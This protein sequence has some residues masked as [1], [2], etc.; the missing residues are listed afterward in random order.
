KGTEVLLTFLDGDPDRPVIQ[1][2]VP[3]SETPSV[4]T[5]AGQTSSRIESG[6]GHKVVLED[7]EGKEGVGLFASDGAGDGSWIWMGKQSPDSFE[8]KSKGN[9]HELVIGQEDSFVLGSESYYTLGS[10]LDFMVGMATE[11][12]FAEKFAFE[13][14][15]SL[16]FKYGTH[17]EFGKSSETIK[18]SSDLL[19]V[20][21]V[22][23]RAGLDPAKKL[24]LTKVRKGMMGA[25]AGVGA[26]S[27]I[28]GGDMATLIFP[29]EKEGKE[30]FNTVGWTSLGFI[31]VGIIA[32]VIAMRSILKKLNTALEHAYS[33]INLDNSGI[34]IHTTVEANQGIHLGAGGGI[35][36]ES[37][38]KINPASNDSIV[39]QRPETTQG[40][41]GGKIIVE[42]VGVS[43]E[44]QGGGSINV[45]EDNVKLAKGT[46]DIIVSD[47]FVM[48]EAG[49]GTEG[50]ITLARTLAEMEQGGKKVS[51]DNGS[52]KMKFGAQTFTLSS[53]SIGVQ[54]SFIKLG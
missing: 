52:I 18:D 36:P 4:I 34:K 13:L 1:S 51:I 2:A 8:V 24:L 7:Q 6:S 17:L 45:S 21:K 46:G 23:I 31:S 29:K 41:G 9:K 32:Q 44:K 50:R 19:G 25:L 48:A 30:A 16:E 47:G 49:T 38:I 26:A 43:L 22:E 20:D 54:G 35:T 15:E 28:I 14:S 40:A 11:I 12:T 10:K 53:E 42:K 3:N 27:A 39:I 37:F 33:E 5:S